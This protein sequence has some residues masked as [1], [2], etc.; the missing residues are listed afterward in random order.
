M[1]KS[2]L[3]ARVAAEASL[4]KADAETAVNAVIGSIGDALAR[5]SHQ[6]ASEGAEMAEFARRTRV[7]ARRRI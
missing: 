7:G 3:F 2:D 1:K 5:I 4:S 6:V